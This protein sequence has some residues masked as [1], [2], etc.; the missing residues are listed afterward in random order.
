MRRSEH[1]V[2]REDRRSQYS[3]FIVCLRPLCSLTLPRE[4]HHRV[5]TRA[6]LVMLWHKWVVLIADRRNLVRLLTQPVL[7][8]VRP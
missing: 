1:E 6:T 8:S 5:Q 4:S 2:G 3:K 7:C